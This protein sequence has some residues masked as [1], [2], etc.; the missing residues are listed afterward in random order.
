MEKNAYHLSLQDV[1]ETG[2]R[3]SFRGYHQRDVDDFLDLVVQD[4]ATFHQEIEDLK[5]EIDQLKKGYVK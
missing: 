1:M 5:S 3:Q 4:Y 2:F